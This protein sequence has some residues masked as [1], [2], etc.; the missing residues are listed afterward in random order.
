MPSSGAYAIGEPSLRSSPTD[1]LLT[2]DRI[3][4]L[5]RAGLDYLQ[6]SIDNVLPDEASK[7][8]LRVLDR[9][10]MAC[11]GGGI[12]GHH[13]FGASAQ[14]CR[15]PRMRSSSARRAREL[16]YTST[17]GILHDHS[18]QLKALTPAH[19][20]VYE[21]FKRLGAPLF[22]FTHFDSFQG[23]I[24]VASR[25]NGIAGPAGGF[26]ISARTDWSTTAR[27]SGDGRNPAR[28]YTA[29]DV[30][31]EAATP[32]GCAPFCTVSCVQQTAMLDGFRER[33]RDAGRDHGAAK[34]LDPAFET[35]ALVRALSWAFLDERRRKVHRRRFGTA[36]GIEPFRALPNAL[37]MRANPSDAPGQV[38]SL[39]QPSGIGNVKPAW[40]RT[41]KGS[42]R[43]RAEERPC[44]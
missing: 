41:R 10:S 3:G 18:G 35:P 43:G 33:P 26:C 28:K 37:S 44:E 2:S 30:R 24:T 27:N 17:I 29:E 36:A 5:N 14:A 9:N 34:E 22:S 15:I 20:S 7:K 31:R 32:K 8:S 19:R 42:I 4:R 39:V 38:R 40:S 25:I 12:R 11:R 16:G 23:N 6:I 21:R 13:Q 1:Y